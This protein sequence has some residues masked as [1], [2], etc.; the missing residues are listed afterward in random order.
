MQ[1]FLETFALLSSEQNNF[2]A[3]LDS[4]VNS[5]SLLRGVHTVFSPWHQTLQTTEIGRILADTHFDELETSGVE[6]AELMAFVEKAEMIE[7][8]RSIYKEAIIRLQRHFRQ[9]QPLT[10]DH[11]ATPR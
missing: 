1:S 6:T 2:S 3:F 8:H 5:I 7:E 9:L 10:E 4:L 11:L